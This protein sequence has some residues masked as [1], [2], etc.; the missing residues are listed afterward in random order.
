MYYFEN[1]IKKY[2]I[3]SYFLFYKK[4]DTIHTCNIVTFLMPSSLCLLTK[5]CRMSYDRKC[6]LKNGVLT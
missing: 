6:Y 5:P 3:L 2:V 4:G 1:K